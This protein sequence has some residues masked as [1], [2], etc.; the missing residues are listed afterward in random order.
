MRSIAVRLARL[1]ARS[2]RVRPAPTWQQVVA[3][4]VGVRLQ[5]QALALPQRFRGGYGMPCTADLQA[6]RNR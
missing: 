4:Q 3:S 6:T 1:L 5:L 2:L